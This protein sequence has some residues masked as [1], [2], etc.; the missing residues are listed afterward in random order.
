MEALRGRCNR[1][2][3][4]WLPALRRWQLSAAKR[5]SPTADRRP[6][7]HHS[8]VTRAQLAHVKSVEIHDEVLVDESAGVS[9]AEDILGS[10]HAP[11]VAEFAFAAIG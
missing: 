4:W 9:E 2:R 1:Q 7:L 8:L 6:A 3:R 11:M 5:Q 10:F